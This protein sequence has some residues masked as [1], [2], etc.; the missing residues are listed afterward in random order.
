MSSSLEQRR[1]GHKSHPEIAAYHQYANKFTHNGKVYFVRF[2]VQ[3]MKVK[4][5]RVG[6]NFAHSS[7][8]SDVE[9]YE[10]SA[11][12]DSVGGRDI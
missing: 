8:V 4:P 12:P 7:F 10:Q 1:E 2:T 5:G 6:P 11:A 9:L 3:Q